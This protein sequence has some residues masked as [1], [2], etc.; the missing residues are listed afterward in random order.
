[1]PRRRKGDEER[2]G[3]GHCALQVAL[4][5]R[6]PHAEHGGAEHAHKGEAHQRP[7]QCECAVLVGA[8]AA[9]AAVAPPR[10]Q[11]R[12]EHRRRGRQRRARAVAV[13]RQRRSERARQQQKCP[14]PRSAHGRQ[15]RRRRRRRPCD[16]LPQQKFPC[17][18]LPQKSQHTLNGW[19]HGSVKRTPQQTQPVEHG[20]DVKRMEGG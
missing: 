17:D 15:R 7:Q 13:Q 3:V 14:V 6:I 19:L 1:M 2:Q 16:Q 5:H 18:Q 10:P 8:R 4:A 20:S 12:G 9:P 11:Q